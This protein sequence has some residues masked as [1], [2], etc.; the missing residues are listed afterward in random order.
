MCT[1][2][3]NKEM[4]LAQKWSKD[5]EPNKVVKVIVHLSLVCVHSVQTYV[6]YKVV[7]ISRESREQS[8][9]ILMESR[10]QMD[11]R[12]IGT[13]WLCLDSSSLTFHISLQEVLIM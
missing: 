13:F 2:E 11:S 6:L 1:P 9:G 4:L 12:G 3:A 8:L 10:A 5:L 7:E